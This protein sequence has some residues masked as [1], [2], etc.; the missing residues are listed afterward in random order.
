MFI[1]VRVRDRSLTPLRGLLILNRS[2][3]IHLSILSSRR[4]ILNLTC[5]RCG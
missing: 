2:L 1:R 3:L 4:L 5:R